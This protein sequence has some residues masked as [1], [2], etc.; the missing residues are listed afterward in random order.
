[1]HVAGL[2]RATEGRRKRN[3]AKINVLRSNYIEFFLFLFFTLQCLKYFPL[4]LTAAA[5]T[6]QEK[7]CSKKKEKA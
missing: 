4:F 3:D 1:M 2:H 7:K 6:N 5:K